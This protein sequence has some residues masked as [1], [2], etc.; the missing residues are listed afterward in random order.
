MY[1]YFNTKVKKTDLLLEL[2]HKGF[3][4]NGHIFLRTINNKLLVTSDTYGLCL[5]MEK[6]MSIDDKK[7]L[8]ELIK[9]I[10]DGLDN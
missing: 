3:E 7:C 2:H 5:D 1:Y 8:Y 10:K 6:N 4:N 9:N